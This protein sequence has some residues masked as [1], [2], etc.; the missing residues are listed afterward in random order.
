MTFNCAKDM[1][2]YLDVV[3]N[4]AFFKCI[5]GLKN[6]MNFLM[7]ICDDCNNIDYDRYSKLQI[8]CC[9]LQDKPFFYSL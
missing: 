4:N 9:L 1:I 6:V 2:R 3:Y 5:F 8:G 7:K